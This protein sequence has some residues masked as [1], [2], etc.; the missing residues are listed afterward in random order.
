MAS[1]VPD[2]EYDV[3]ISYRRK[4]D[5]YDGWV[6]DFVNNLKKELEATFKD[7]VSVYFDLNPTDGILEIHDVNASLKDKLKCLCLYS[8]YFSD[9]L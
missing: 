8:N 4:D 5:K 7:E 3:F 2:Y 9:I 6:T 1:M